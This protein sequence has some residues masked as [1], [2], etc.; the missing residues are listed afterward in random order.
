MR[1]GK[2]RERR[3][4][5]STLKKTNIC[6]AFYGMGNVF[7]SNYFMPLPMARAGLNF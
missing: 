1:C 6:C 3:A 2:K 4:P 5:R 7:P